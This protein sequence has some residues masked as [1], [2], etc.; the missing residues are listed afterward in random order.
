[1]DDII[2]LVSCTNEDAYKV[3]SHAIEWLSSRKKPFA[4][5]TCCGRYRSGKSFLLNR[6]CNHPPNRGFNVGDTINSCTKGLWIS[7]KSIAVNDD[8]DLFVVDVEGLESNDASE[9]HDTRLVSLAILISNIFLYNSV[10]V[11]DEGAIRTLSYMA[12]VADSLQEQTTFPTFLWVLRDFSLEMVDRSGKGVSNADYLEECL[13]GEDTTRAAIKQMFTDRRLF[14][15]PRPSK[16]D[17]TQKLDSK[18]SNIN[19]KFIQQVSELRELILNTASPM[20]ASGTSMSGSVFVKFC[21]NLVELIQTDAVPKLQDT[22]T[23]VANMQRQELIYDIVDDARIQVEAWPNANEL[24]MKSKLEELMRHCVDIFLSR[25]TGSH[26]SR[27][28]VHVLLQPLIAKATSSKIQEKTINLSDLSRKTF[29]TLESSLDDNFELQTIRDSVDDFKKEHGHDACAAH[30]LPLIV[31]ALLNKWFPDHETANATTQ[32]IIDDLRAKLSAVTQQREA[33]QNAF[34][35]FK[36]QTLSHIEQNVKV[37]VENGVQTDDM[38]CDMEDVPSFHQNDEELTKTTEENN[39][40]RHKLEQMRLE[41]QKLTKRVQD[42]ISELAQK[43]DTQRKHMEHR[44]QQEYETRKSIEIERNTLAE[45][46]KKLEVQLRDSQDRIVQVHKSSLEELRSKDALLRDKMSE[47]Q[48]EQTELQ[49]ACAEQSRGAA[50]ATT[51]LGYLKRQLE[52]YDDV[53]HECKKIRTEMQ[54]LSVQKSRC[55]TELDFLKGHSKTLVEERNELQRQNLQLENKLAMLQTS[56]DI[57][58]Y[59]KTL[60]D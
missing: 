6:L 11:I 12:R 28:D 44:F 48:R 40:L 27:S 17:S 32:T 51:E 19:S 26:S 34:E 57:D 55:E 58:M 16:T 7:K 8:L 52:Q 29:E 21:E 4:I 60:S 47:W 56:V 15:L 30:Y 45:R 59:R 14:T 1:M 9:T 23:M 25:S 33:D 35:I 24:T 5:I 41:F 10:G 42:E 54:Q 31:H 18:H 49:T 53:Q 36:Q 46:N 22:W 20:S 13:S 43:S 2:P 39:Q 50:C 3:N 38:V 37:C